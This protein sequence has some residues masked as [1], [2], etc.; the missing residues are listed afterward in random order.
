M[1]KKRIATIAILSPVM[2]GMGVVV[3]LVAGIGYALNG[4]WELKTILKEDFHLSL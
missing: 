2:L 4:K 3:L 1:T